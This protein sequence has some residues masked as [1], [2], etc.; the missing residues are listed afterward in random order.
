MLPEGFLSADASKIRF[1]R[2]LQKPET[3]GKIAAGKKGA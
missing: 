2:W 3:K 1:E